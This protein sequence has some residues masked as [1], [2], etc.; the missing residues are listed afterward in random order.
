MD[1]TL[2][3]HAV[4]TFN[5]LS[6]SNT[7]TAFGEAIPCALLIVLAIDKDK[8]YNENG[9]LGKVLSSDILSRQK[10]VCAASDKGRLSD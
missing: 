7:S 1:R 5:T 9:I 3:N 6:S 10:F 8:S 4:K 2:F